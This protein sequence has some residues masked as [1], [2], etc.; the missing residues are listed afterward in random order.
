[1]SEHLKVNTLFLGLT[2]PAMTMGVTHE[3]FVIS[4][5]LS[6]CAFI[7]ANNIFLALIWVP[8]HIVGVLAHRHDV[9]FVK[10]LLAKAK[11]PRTANFKTWGLNAYEP[12]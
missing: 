5:L 4:A 9:Q 10:V 11:F 1:M 8:I 7:L 2:R 12:Y 6:M 3:Y